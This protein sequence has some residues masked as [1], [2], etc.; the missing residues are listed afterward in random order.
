MIKSLKFIFARKQ[1]LTLWH[2][3]NRLKGVL[4]NKLIWPFVKNQLSTCDVCGNRTY[5]R[6]MNR[7]DDD[8]PICQSCWDDNCYYC[9]RG[10]PEHETPDGE[11][12]CTGC[13]SGN[14]SAIHDSL[15]DR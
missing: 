9:H 8:Q 15:E 14:M 3:W 4:Y 7:D 6:E 1:N 2:R 12:I 13:H 11:Y 10:D 5:R